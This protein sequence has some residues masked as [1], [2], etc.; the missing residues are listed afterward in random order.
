MGSMRT[1]KA[2]DGHEFGAY[3]AIPEGTQRGSLVVIQEI[4]GVNSHMQ[5]VCDGFAGEGYLSI[6]PAVFDRVEPGVDLGYTPED[7]E[8]GRN[9]MGQLSWRNT[10]MDVEAAADAVSD[11]KRPGIIGYCYGGSVAWLAACRLDLT[12][13]V[14]YYGGMIIDFVDETPNCPTMLHF[15]EQDAGIPMSDVKE[16][17]DKH[18]EVTTHAYAEAQ[19]GFSCDHRGSYHETH[20]KLALERTNAFFFQQ[21]L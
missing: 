7:I 12:C 21:F 2:S 8:R 18:P 13:A 4:F 14:S 11:G 6:A 17:S 16:I 15:G 3:E 1:L 5:E 20:A 9:I 19:H 10:M